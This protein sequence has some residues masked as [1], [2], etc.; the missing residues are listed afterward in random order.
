MDIQSIKLKFIED[1]LRL[2]NEHLILKLNE[3]LNREK[4]KIYENSLKP[5][6]INELHKKIG[7][8]EKDI[9]EGN[10]FT[11]DQVEEIFSKKNKS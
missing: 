9:E 5:M 11:Q 7:Q 6:T 4:K 3:F 1:F 2:Q 10:V 8:A